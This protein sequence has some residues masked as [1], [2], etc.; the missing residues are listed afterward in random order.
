MKL[1]AGTHNVEKSGNFEESKFSIEASSKA[2][3]ILSDGLYSNKILAVVRELSTNAYDSHVEAGKADAAFDVHLPTPLK[4]VFFIRDYGTSMN[5]DNCMQL[6]TTYFRSTRNNSNDAVGCLGLGS[7]APFA[8]SDSF[9]VEAYLDGTCRIYSGYKNQDGSP[10]FSMMEEVPTNEPNGIKVSINV[11]DYDVNRF[12]HEA[13]KV[14][15]YFKVK[16]NFVSDTINYKS[17]NKVLAGDNWYFDDDANNNLVIMGQIAYPLDGNQLVSNDDPSNRYRNFIEYSDGLRIFLNIGDVD[18]TPSRESL[19]YSKETK[20]NIRATINKIM[21]DISMKIEEEIKSQPSLYKARMKY[22]QIS[23]QCSSIKS[24]IESL[25]KSICW[26]N[27]KLFD[28]VAGEYIEIKDKITCNLLNK[29]SYRKKIDTE[30]KVERFHF[31]GHNKFVIDDL[32]R[33]GLSRLKQYM[34]DQDGSVSC[35]VYKLADGETIDSCKLYDTMGGATKNDVIITSSLPKVE[36]NRSSS[37]Y[38]SSGPAIQARVFNEEKG[39]FVECNM[40]VQ[41]ENAHYFI[42][43]K[44]TVTI[45]HSDCDIHTLETALAFAHKNYNDIIEGMTFYIVKPS[46]AKNRKLA[47]RDNWFDGCKTLETVFKDAVATYKQDIIDVI[48]RQPLS[49]ERNERWLDVL[50]LTKTDSEAKK[51]AAEYKQYTKRLDNLIV[52]VYMIQD[53]ARKFNHGVEINQIKAEKNKFADRFDEEIKKYPMLKVCSNVWDDKQRKT[54]AEYIDTIEI[55]VQ[56]Q[57]VLN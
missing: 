24:A 11:N 6:Y 57:S 28:S 30:H 7:K 45:G 25:Q 15:E 38:A 21:N 2:F 32:T 54:V 13:H 5:H 56:A 50:K 18:I 48:S 44:G 36:Y 34:K 39:G 43:S 49:N 55:G 19:S 4:P 47:D 14:Y 29:G 10:T 26:N 37:G 22:V 52:D 42:E 27:T 23:D 51:I 41:Y 33:G 8:Y 35:Y 12:H 40:S 53:V 46:V 1:H 16:P 20:E 3:F 9:T 31:N 17:V